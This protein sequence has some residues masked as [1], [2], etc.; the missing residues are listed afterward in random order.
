MTKAQE[1]PHPFQVNNTPLW[2]LPLKRGT[3]RMVHVSP[4]RSY[5]KALWMPPQRFQKWRGA[6]LAWWEKTGKR[7]SISPEMWV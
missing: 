3:F 2:L 6:F 1:L 7:L 5:G 4:K